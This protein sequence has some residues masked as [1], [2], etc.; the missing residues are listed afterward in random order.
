MNLHFPNGT[1]NWL[2]RSETPPR[3]IC[4]HC[5]VVC[6]K[7]KWNR[8]RLAKVTIYFCTQ[9]CTSTHFEPKDLDDDG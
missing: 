8:I 9:E 5:G 4:Y 2:D 6:I 1:I 7:G 3:P